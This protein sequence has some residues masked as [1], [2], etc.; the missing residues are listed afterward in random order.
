MIRISK[1]PAALDRAR[2]MCVRLSMY[3]VETP[4]GVQ[5]LRRMVALARKH[6]FSALEVTSSTLRRSDQ[7]CDGLG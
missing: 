5:L 6:G 7:S 1:R 4:A 2:D 3:G